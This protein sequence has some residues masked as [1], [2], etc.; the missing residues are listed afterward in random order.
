MA[1]TLVQSTTNSSNSGSSLTFTLPGAP[2]LSDGKYHYIFLGISSNTGNMSM[3]TSSDYTWYWQ[4]VYN[5]TPTTH[6]SLFIGRIFTGAAA[7]FTVNTVSSGEYSG[8]AA[9]FKSDNPIRVDR[10][11]TSTGNSTSPATG[12]TPTLSASSELAVAV[13][14]QRLQSASGTGTFTSPTNSFTEVSAGGISTTNNTAN[15][16]RQV[17]LLYKVTSGTTGVSTGLTSSISNNWTGLIVTMQDALGASPQV[18]RI[19]GN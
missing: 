6:A 11:A 1:Y 7:T 18:S 4:V 14:A 3:T 15:G 13:L 19:H 8:I 9:E 5:N 17:D 10:Y 12:T 16:D 2:D